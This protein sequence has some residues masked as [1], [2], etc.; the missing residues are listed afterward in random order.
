RGRHSSHDKDTKIEK[1]LEGV[2]IIPLQILPNTAPVPVAVVNGDVKQ[3]GR[4]I[5][6]KLV[7]LGKKS[8][9]NIAFAWYMQKN[10]TVSMSIRTDGEPDAAKV[11]EHLRKTMGVTGGGHAGAGAV[12]FASLF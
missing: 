7:E 4:K 8:G 1:L 9:G 3:Y 11:A 12:H 10:G 6:E 5:S 2:N